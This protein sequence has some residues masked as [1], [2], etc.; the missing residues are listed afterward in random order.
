MIKR[1]KYK[2]G[3]IKFSQIM[4]IQARSGMREKCISIFSVF[5]FL[6]QM[7]QNY[8]FC[9]FHS[10]LM[11]RDHEITDYEKSQREIHEQIVEKGNLIAPIL[12]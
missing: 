5:I 9:K 11:I 8:I 3:Q 2:K 6:V 4:L 10:L 1:E 12:S 7:N